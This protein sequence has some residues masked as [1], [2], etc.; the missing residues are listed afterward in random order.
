MKKLLEYLKPCKKAYDSVVCAL[1]NKE[2][3]YYIQNIIAAFVIAF[4]ATT[5]LFMKVGEYE[6]FATEYVA[7]KSILFFCFDMIL[8][9]AR[10]LY[11]F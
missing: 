2:K 9:F 8:F 1:S 11:Y 10:G 4:F 6:Y 3:P 7:S 5:A